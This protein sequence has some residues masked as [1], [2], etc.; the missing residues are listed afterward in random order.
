MLVRAGTAS[1]AELVLSFRL[2]F[3]HPLLAAIVTTHLLSHGCG[4]EG[5]SSCVISAVSELGIASALLSLVV[6]HHLCL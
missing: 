6:K 4:R 1:A 3:C 2:T 5:H